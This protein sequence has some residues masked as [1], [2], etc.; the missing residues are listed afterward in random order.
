[1]QPSSSQKKGSQKH[2]DWVEAPE[3]NTK[4]S[5]SSSVPNPGR[6]ISFSTGTQ[7]QEVPS[8]PRP[9]PQPQETPADVS[10]QIADPADLG[11]SSVVPPE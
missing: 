8:P 5:T 4:L 10:E 7:M 11:T 9:V 6:I 2:Q 3:D 1:M